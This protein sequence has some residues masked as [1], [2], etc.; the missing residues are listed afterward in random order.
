LLGLAEAE[1]GVILLHV[2]EFSKN[3]ELVSDILNTLLNYHA[4]ERRGLVLPVCT[5]HYAGVG[6]LAHL[7]A[8]ES[9]C[10]LTMPYFASTEATLQLM[11][12]AAKAYLTAPHVA[13]AA[14]T[15]SAPP[16]SSLLEVEPLPELLQYLVEDMEGWAMAAV[17]LGAHLASTPWS[18]R[19]G[20]L[21]ETLGAVEEA[22]KA[23]LAKVYTAKSILSPFG[24]AHALKFAAI[25][26][27]PFTVR[28]KPVHTMRRF[29]NVLTP[30]VILHRIAGAGGFVGAHERRNSKGFSK[31]RCCQLGTLREQSGQHPRPGPRPPQPTAAAHYC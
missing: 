31:V 27:S 4:Q 17:Q 29:V 14:A 18:R 1:C 11:R 3:P 16:L 5:G 21:R 26:L 9:K 19:L 2:D 7:T 12:N 23:Y 10:I 8:S 24:S 22:H 25:A 28:G 13:Q 15:T 30:V 6:V 20:E